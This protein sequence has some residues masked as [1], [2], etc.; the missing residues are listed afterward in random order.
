MS[1]L[2]FDYRGYGRSEGACNEAGLRQD[3]RAARAWLARR[4]RV[5]ERDVVL[6]GRSIGGGVVVDLAT[7]GA[8][9]LVLESTF[10]SL[11]DVAAYHY[12][13]LPVRLLMR[14]RFDSLGKIARYH[15]PL[16]ASHGDADTTI[17]FALGRRLFDAAN[18]PKQF[19]TI[20][21]G[22][23]NDMPPPEYYNLLDRFIGNLP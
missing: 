5:N 15:G 8:R 23:H 2:L 16:L 7:D 14:N 13:W 22:D 9:G 20:V 6:F 3:G 21:G 18:P 10:T 12:P 4:A 17:P 11:P 19:Y 1:I